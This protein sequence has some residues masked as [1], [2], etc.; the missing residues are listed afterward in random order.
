ML[1]LWCFGLFWSYILD[2]SKMRRN[3]ICE[4]KNRFLLNIEVYSELY[5]LCCLTVT[6]SYNFNKTFL[7]SVKVKYKFNW[8]NLAKESHQQ[9]GKGAWRWIWQTD[10]K[11]SVSSCYSW[12]PQEPMH[13]HTE[14]HN[15][16]TI[17][18]TSCTLL[19]L[20]INWI[21]ITIQLRIH[22]Y[23]TAHNDNECEPCVSSLSHFILTT[24]TCAETCSGSLI[25]AWKCIARATSR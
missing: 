18:Y 9:I 3:V 8:V 2:I 21:K 4:F 6:H 13:T 19:G 23:V 12:C 16:T 11:A 10:I 15:V 17:K 5:V 14:T 25:G 22:P 24:T 1:F 7:I 20:A